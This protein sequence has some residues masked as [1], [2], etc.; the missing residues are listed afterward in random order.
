MGPPEEFC[1]LVGSFPALDPVEHAELPGVAL[2]ETETEQ[3]VSPGRVDGPVLG[4]QIAIARFVAFHGRNEDEK[5]DPDERDQRI[6]GRI[7][8]ELRGLPEHTHDDEDNYQ[9]EGKQREGHVHL[10]KEFERLQGEFLLLFCGAHV[11]FLLVLEKPRHI[12]PRVD[13]R[14]HIG[15]E[16]TEFVRRGFDGLIADRRPVVGV[17]VFSF[18]DDS[19]ELP[20]HLAVGI[21]GFRHRF[22]NLQ[23]V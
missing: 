9:E 6:H 1:R 21:V 23:L 14:E 2:D 17:E 19:L 7:E 22:E 15:Q 4:A 5:P 3:R 20:A 8:H 16:L 13:D 18:L 12:T 11:F 10:P